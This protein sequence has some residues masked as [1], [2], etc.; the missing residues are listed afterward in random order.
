MVAGD[1]IT[2]ATCAIFFKPRQGHKTK[3]FLL[4]IVSLLSRESR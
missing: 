2:G 3:A 4:T 1:E